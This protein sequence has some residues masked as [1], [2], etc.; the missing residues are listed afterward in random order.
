MTIYS[1]HHI[2]GI[3]LRQGDD[4]A[5]LISVTGNV[6]AWDGATFTAPALTTCGKV[7][8]CKGGTFSAPVLTESGNIFHEIAVSEYTLFA[9]PTL[10]KSGCRG[11]W[12]ADQALAHW[13]QR[14]DQRAVMFTAAI[15]QHEASK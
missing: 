10:Y 5:N 1:G 6:T 11:P 7:T 9:S 13:S 4:C 3:A 15:K 2:G 12:T 14:S 8:V